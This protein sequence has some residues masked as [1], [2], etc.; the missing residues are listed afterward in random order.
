M[1]TLILAKT[2]RDNLMMQLHEKY[3]L[4]NWKQNKG[5]P[6]KEHKEKII[7]CGISDHHRKSFKLLEKQYSFD[8]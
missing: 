2:Y 1:A 6:T 4:Y 7:N 8:F 3:P 5:Y